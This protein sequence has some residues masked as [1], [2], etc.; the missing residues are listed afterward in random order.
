VVRWSEEALAPAGP[1]PDGIADDRAVHIVTDGAGSITRA[2]ARELGITLLDSYVL[3]GDRSLPETLLDPETL[4]AA[5]AGGIRVS[6]AQASVSERHERYRSL[7]SQYGRV[8]YLC[9]GSVFTGNYDLVTAWK[10]ENDPDNRL[11]V[12]DTGAA[13]GR[14]GLIALAA[15]RRALQNGDG[16]AI[17][18]FARTAV[19]QCREYIFLDRLKYLAAGGRLSKSKGF[20]G[21]MLGVKPVISPTAEGVIRVG[22]VRSRDEQIRFVLEKL[23]VLSEKTES[24]LILLQYSDNRDWVETEVMPAVSEAAPRAEILVQPL[25]V[26]SG[27]HMGPG[28]WSIAIFPGWE[29]TPSKR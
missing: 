13:S 18:R 3:I 11:A 15:A 21:D 5:M 12:I 4:Y 19:D 23:A 17:V 28:T 24:P 26:T 9:V 22:T 6:T 29:E 25:S 1:E 10:R 14:L 8:L 2:A 27:A 7:L 20:F 16:D